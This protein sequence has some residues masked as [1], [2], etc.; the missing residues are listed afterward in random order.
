MEFKVSPLTKIISLSGFLALGFLLVILSCALFHNYYPLYDI[1][2]FILAPV[3]NAIFG[4]RSYG[5]SD[6]MSDSSNNGKDLGHFFTGMF[7]T[8]G[9]LMPVIF[10]HCQ[11]I[12]S[13]SC[14]MSM[15]G[16]LIIYSSIVIFSWFFHSSWDNEEDNLFG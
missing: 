7:V 12:G 6:F 3:P 16:G 8:S 2:V 4:G 14:A 15:I 11:L 1:L 5:S 10:Y 9:I 13:V